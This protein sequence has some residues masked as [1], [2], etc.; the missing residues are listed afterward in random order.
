MKSLVRGTSALFFVAAILFA[1]TQPAAAA[2]SWHTWV[3]GDQ[4]GRIPP[5]PD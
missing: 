1:T 4:T 5:Y 3:P 2:F